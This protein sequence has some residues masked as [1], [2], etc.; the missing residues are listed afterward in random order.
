MTSPSDASPSRFEPRRAAGPLPSFGFAAWGVVP[1]VFAVSALAQGPLHPAKL[2][3]GAIAFGWWLVAIL[4]VRGVRGAVTPALALVAVHWLA[5]AALEVRRTALVVRGGDVEREYGPGSSA[6]DLPFYWAL[7]AAL[8]FLPLT[9]I[10]V[11]LWAALRH[12]RPYP[13]V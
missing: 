2:A 3:L 6:M 7:E 1:T 13:S 5:V 9:V 11:R 4:L 8:V 12:G 10:G